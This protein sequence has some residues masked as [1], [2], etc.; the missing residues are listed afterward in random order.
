MPRPL[1]SGSGLPQSPFSAATSST[2]NEIR[3]VRQQAA[4]EFVRVFAGGMGELVD[5]AL[6]D[7]GVLRAADVRQNMTGTWVFLRHA[8]DELGGRGI[9]L[10]GEALHRRG[11]DAAL[12]HRLPAERA[13]DRPD[14]S[15]ADRIAAISAFTSRRVHRSVACGR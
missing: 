14:G 10:I 9:G 6:H 7:E 11:L 12:G 15:A 4:A 3:P 5:E 2:L 1:P 13:G 8:F